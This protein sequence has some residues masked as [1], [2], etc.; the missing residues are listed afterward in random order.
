MANQWKI[1][2]WTSTFRQIASIIVRLRQL[3]DSLCRSRRVLDAG[4][5][6]K[7]TGE[8]IPGGHDSFIY[9]RHEPVG[10]CGQIIPWCVSILHLL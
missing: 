5:V 8:T 9:T 2:K 6:D 4:W 1:V 7:I 3:I 10:I